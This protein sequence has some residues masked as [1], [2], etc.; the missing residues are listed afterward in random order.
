MSLLK[1]ALRDQR[2][3]VVVGGQTGLHHLF[4]SALTAKEM[5][6]WS[7]IRQGCIISLV[8]SLFDQ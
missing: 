1:D 5:A 4:G 7:V 8:R 3:G 2:D 6:S